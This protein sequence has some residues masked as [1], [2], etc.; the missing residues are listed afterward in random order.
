M[1]DI[2]DIM[3]NLE[4]ITQILVRTVPVEGISIRFLCL[5]NGKQG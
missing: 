2:P 3:E 1:N 4:E 5:R